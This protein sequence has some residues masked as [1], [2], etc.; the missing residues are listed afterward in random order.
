VEIVAAL[1]GNNAFDRRGST[2]LHVSEYY[3]FTRRI[4]PFTAGVVTL[5]DQSTDDLWPDIPTVIHNY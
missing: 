2:N 4:P 3:L 1:V 5:A